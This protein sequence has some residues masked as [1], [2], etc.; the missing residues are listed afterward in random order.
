MTND[1]A[2]RQFHAKLQAALASLSDDQL[3]RLLAVFR[4]GEAGGL[5][6]ALAVLRATR[7]RKIVY[8]PAFRGDDGRAEGT[9]R[10]PIA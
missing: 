5:E 2:R 7:R 1:E 4:V 8:G 3:E 10:E 6:A 9:A